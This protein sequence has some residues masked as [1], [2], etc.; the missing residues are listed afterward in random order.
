MVQSRATRS[1]S[2][3]G[4]RT[5][6]RTTAGK[7]ANKSAGK[8]ARKSAPQSASKRVRKSAGKV[9]HRYSAATA[10]KYELYQKAVQSPEG[11]V[12]FLQ[13]MFERERGRRALRLRE[14]FCG[15]A[16]LSSVWIAQSPAHTAEGYDIDPEPV[17]WGLEHNFARAQASQGRSKARARQLPSPE[18]FEFHLK[19]VRAPSLRPVDLRVAFNF[20]YWIFT[21]RAELVRYFEKARESLVSDGIFCLDLY[22]GWEATQ[23]MVETRRC[24]GFTYVWDQ[25][26]YH[27]GTGEYL[28]Q[29]RFRFPDK[30]ELKAFDYRWRY[31]TLNEIRDA[32]VDAGFSEVHTY[33]EG[34]TSKGEGDGVFRRGTRGENCEAWL[35]YLVAL[36]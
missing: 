19:D 25:R 18:R 36:R 6:A 4:A 12:P 16:Y 26:R 3:A 31:W 35:C 29:I 24:G 34:T 14:D 11:D 32:L 23:E 8:S 17:A 28:T 10:D 21:E 2:A 20:S 27:P 15:T 30:T 1:E 5:T 22:G 33:F 13:R 7:A 9:R